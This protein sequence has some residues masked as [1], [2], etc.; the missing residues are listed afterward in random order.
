MI[1]TLI[2]ALAMLI[3]VGASAAAQ[4]LAALDHPRLKAQAVVTGDVVRVG[5][6]VE[7]AGIIATVPIFRAPDLG[8][9]GSVP[10]AAVVEAERGHAL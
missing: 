9:T 6:L 2:A 8:M 3:A 7:H 5:D 10:A 1:R 4:E